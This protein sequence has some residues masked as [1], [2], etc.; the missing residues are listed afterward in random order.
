MSSACPRDQKKWETN[1]D[2]RSQVTCD[3]TPC[4]ENT[5]MM[6]SWASCGVVISSTV[7]MN[8]PRLESQSTM[9]R[10]V[11]CPSDSGRC[12]IKSM[13]IEFHGRSGTGSC[14]RSP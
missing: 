5:W 3:R 13:E 14:L 8:I 7:G 6:N 2:L 1:S 12:S 11:V 4:L 9:T 10:I